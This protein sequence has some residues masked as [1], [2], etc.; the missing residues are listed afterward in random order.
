MNGSLVSHTKV[1][2]TFAAGVSPVLQTRA[3]TGNLLG[4]SLTLLL[5][6][7]I[8]FQVMGVISNIAAALLLNC[9]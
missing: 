4:P 5:S 2:S 7:P 3:P 1:D 9:G 8:T 6:K